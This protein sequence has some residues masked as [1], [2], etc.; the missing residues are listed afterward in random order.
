MTNNATEMWLKTAENMFERMAMGK[1]VT[2][3]DVLPRPCIPH[4]HASEVKVATQGAEVMAETAATLRVNRDMLRV[5]RTQI[6]ESERN[7]H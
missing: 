5:I 4:T 1:A 2:L 3:Q 7:E 6:E